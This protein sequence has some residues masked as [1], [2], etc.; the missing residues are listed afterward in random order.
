MAHEIQA[1]RAQSPAGV[2][3]TRDRKI[4]IPPVDIVESKDAI[5]LTAD[6]PGVDEKNVHV[7]LEKSVLTVLGEIEPVSVKDRKLAYEEYEIG[8]FERSF[9]LSDEIDP[10][11]IEATLKNGVLRLVLP[12][13]EAARA[14]KIPVKTA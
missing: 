9:T 3:H 11:R 1:V 14:K 2:E 12:K 7:T 5:L 13:T 10:D 4:F 6:M 8:D